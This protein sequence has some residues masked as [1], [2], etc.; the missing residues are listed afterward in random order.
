MTM[1]TCHTLVPSVLLALLALG[2]SCG[3]SEWGSSIRDTACTCQEMCEHGAALGCSQCQDPYCV[4]RCEQGFE[5]EVRQLHCENNSSSCR[6]DFGGD[7]AAQ[8]DHP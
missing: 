2:A 8:C 1:M 4:S 3:D 7:T 5:A 6:T